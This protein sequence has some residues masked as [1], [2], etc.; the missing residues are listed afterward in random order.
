MQVFLIR[1]ERKC[2]GCKMGNSPAKLVWRFEARQSKVHSGQRSK[3]HST[4]I[5]SWRLLAEEKLQTQRTRKPLWYINVERFASPHDMNHFNKRPVEVILHFSTE[6]WGAY[7]YSTMWKLGSL[8]LLVRIA[9]CLTQLCKSVNRGP[10]L[11]YICL[12]TRL[13]C[14]SS[15]NRRG[16]TLRSVNSCFQTW[17]VR[18]YRFFISKNAF[19]PK[20][21]ESLWVLLGFQHFHWAFISINYSESLCLFYVF[22]QG[23][24]IQYTEHWPL[25]HANCNFA[26][27]EL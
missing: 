20:L 3:M 19:F 8:W 24:F 22:A 6:T 27:Y 5:C 7:F 1:S 11:I 16:V 26:L 25:T 14:F 12:W 4:H 9:G 21:N 10:N 13:Q 18:Q 15:C 23:L 17:T 2:D